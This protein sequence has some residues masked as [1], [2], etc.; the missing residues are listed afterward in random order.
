MKNMKTVAF[1]VATTIFCLL[2]VSAQ[3]TKDAGEELPAGIR[4]EY[5]DPKF[6][7]N[8]RLYETPDFSKNF[9]KV[10]V[11]RYAHVR[12]EKLSFSDL[13]YEKLAPEFHAALAMK[14]AALQKYCND[15]SNNQCTI[16]IQSGNVLF[17]QNGIR[18][19]TDRATLKRYPTNTIFSVKDGEII[20]KIP[21]EKTI[22]T[23]MLADD[24]F[25][26]EQ[27][28][29]I[30]IE[31]Q[32]P[33][34]IEQKQITGTLEY[35]Q[36]TWTMPAHKTTTINNVELTTSEEAAIYGLGGTQDTELNKLAAFFET[37]QMYEYLRN[38]QKPAIFV[39]QN[40]IYAVTAHCETCDISADTLHVTFKPGNPY[41]TMD[42][43]NNYYQQFPDQLAIIPVNGGGIVSGAQQLTI[44]GKVRM[45]N[46]A[47]TLY[48]DNGEFSIKTTT[49]ATANYDTVPLYLQLYNN[50]FQNPLQGMKDKDGNELKNIIEINENNLIRYNSAVH[51]SSVVDPA[52]IVSEPESGLEVLRILNTHQ[53]FT[54]I[55]Q[56]PYD[57]SNP[58]EK[59]Y[60]EASTDLIALNTP[61]AVILKMKNTEDLTSQEQQKR[62][63]IHRKFLE[64][65]NIQQKRLGKEGQIFDMYIIGHSG[66]GITDERKVVT[67]IAF[68][69]QKEKEEAIAQ[70]I[71]VDFPEHII[72]S[73]LAKQKLFDIENEIGSELI[74]KGELQ[75]D[76][77]FKDK[78]DKII[79]TEKGRKKTWPK[80]KLALDKDNEV[81]NK[82]YIIPYNEKGIHGLPTID[83]SF[84]P[85]FS[86]VQLIK[87]EVP[88]I[89][90]K[91]ISEILVSSSMQ[92]VY[93]PSCS[94]AKSAENIVKKIVG[95]EVTYTCRSHR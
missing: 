24:T 70:K 28:K 25:R 1:I 6:Y 54:I 59:K 21:E 45:E 77:Y 8:E 26:L 84:A 18:T 64:G 53:K 75:K 2:L 66:L 30:T 4:D 95:K 58:A 13:P 41:Y 73:L 89:R 48:F 27:E 36:G 42:E 81:Q 31:H 80:I 76:D 37:R 88:D 5:S 34:G 47:H 3:E 52:H 60:F 51:I 38:K 35:N 15:I 10:P 65:L 62:L 43:G 19:Q 29:I 85:L 91:P 69:H 90:N 16:D 55:V 32:T 44:V 7:Q 14:K 20:I 49:E 87:K 78:K 11:T 72:G 56:T 68:G 40:K 63:E 33:N 61:Q 92:R 71:Q 93:F 82:M 9:N 46:G 39:G 57:N 23:D 50:N 74:K 86:A 79:F 67:E 17:D 94:Y 83:L 12:F 22:R